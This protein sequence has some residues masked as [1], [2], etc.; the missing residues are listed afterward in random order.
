MAS[1]EGKMMFASII[2]ENRI[3]LSIVKIIAH[4]V[5]KKIW[6]KSYHVMAT[7]I[8]AQ[9]IYFS[10]YEQLFVLRFTFL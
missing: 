6:D 1:K 3:Y 8:M 7:N 9:L 2:T 10:D 4:F 5:K